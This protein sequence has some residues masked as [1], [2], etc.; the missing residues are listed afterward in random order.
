MS[1]V[2]AIL[3]VS[4][5]ALSVSGAG[6]GGVN[7]ETSIQGTDIQE[8]G[9]SNEAYAGEP[10]VLTILLNDGANMNGTEVNWVT[11]VCINSGI[12][13]P[14][15]T[16]AMTWDEEEMNWKD[17]I[18]PEDTATYVNWRVEINWEDGNTTSIPESGFGWKVWSDCWYDG[19]NW[20]GNDSSCWPGEDRI[21]GFVAPLTLA[22][23]GIAGLMIRRD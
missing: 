11:Q 6:E 22:A 5:L 12:C 9:Y 14:P 10:F 3:L 18:V 13:Y 15:E 1:R 7:E 21:P 19:S 16:H 2:V 4:M 17:S 23:I 8:I 20:G